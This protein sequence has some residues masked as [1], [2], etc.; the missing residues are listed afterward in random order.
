MDEEGGLAGRSEG[1]R[2]LARNMPGFADA[3]HNDAAGR[4]RDRLDRLRE[5]GSKSALARRPDSL[6]KRI[7]ALALGGDRTKRR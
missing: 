4:G 7:E 5:R 2:D 6:L 3:G 1:G